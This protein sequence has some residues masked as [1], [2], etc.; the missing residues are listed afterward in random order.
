MQCIFDFS[1][2]HPS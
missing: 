1:T 2:P